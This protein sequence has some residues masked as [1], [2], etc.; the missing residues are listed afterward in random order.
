MA[1]PEVANI[2]TGNRSSNSNSTS[3]AKPD[4]VTDTSLMLVLLALDDDDDLGSTSTPGWSLTRYLGED[5]RLLVAY[6]WGTASWPLVVSH[7][8]EPAAWLVLRIEGADALPYLSSGAKGESASPDPPELSPG[9]GERDFLWVAA[10]GTQ[11]GD[12]QYSPTGGPP[13]YTGYTSQ[14]SSSSTLNSST[15]VYAAHRQMRAASE[16][17]GAFTGQAISETWVAVTIGISGIESSLSAPI[18]ARTPSGWVNHP[19]AD[20]IRV[21]TASGWDPPL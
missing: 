8:N 1:F 7:D 17:P 19:Y 6:G 10:G 15:G 5:D 9:I 4:G 14:P 18:R 2:T 3:V 20:R 13:G 16:N 21:R 11:V 12:P